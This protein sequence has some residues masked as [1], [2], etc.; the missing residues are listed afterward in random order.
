MNVRKSVVATVS[1]MVLM[2]S[3]AAHGSDNGGYAKD[4]AEGSLKSNHGMTLC[5]AAINSDGTVAGGQHVN[6]NDTARTS[7]GQYE[8]AFFKPCND[9]R[10]SQGFMRIMQVD[11]LDDTFVVPAVC[12]TADRNGNKAA[13][14]IF[15]SDLDGNPIDVSFFLHVS[16]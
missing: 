16:R 15:C 14:Y 3:L 1:A 2:G 11:A 9:V 6:K 5:T 8:V 12:S 7:I 10:A 13:V 4:V